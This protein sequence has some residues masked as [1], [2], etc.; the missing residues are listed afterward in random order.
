MLPLP[1]RLVLS[2]LSDQA[3][4]LGALRMALEATHQELDLL[5]DQ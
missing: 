5:I 2:A 3:V 1:P 4:A